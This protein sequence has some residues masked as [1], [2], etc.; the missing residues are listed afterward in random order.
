M[1]ITA[2]ATTEEILTEIG[3]RL[4]QYRLQQNRTAQNVADATGLKLLTIQRAERGSNPTLDTVIRI[5]RALNRLDALDAFLPAPLASPLDLARLSGRER[6]RAG[7]PRR[8][9]ESRGDD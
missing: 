7:T 6:Q 8:R 5:L 3:E 9:K 2:A 4:R 1:R